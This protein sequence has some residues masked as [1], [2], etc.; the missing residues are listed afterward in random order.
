[1]AE[2]IASQM[3]LH[4]IKFGAV[5]TWN[6]FLFHIFKVTH[7]MLMKYSTFARLSIYSF[8]CDGLPEMYAIELLHGFLSIYQYIL[9]FIYLVSDEARIHKYLVRI[10]I[11]VHGMGFL[12]NVL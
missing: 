9:F 10:S 7:A 1:M 2:Y 4:K 8:R 3:K 11:Y 12:I 6:I 5:Q